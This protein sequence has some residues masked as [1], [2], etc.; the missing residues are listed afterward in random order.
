MLDQ[1]GNLLKI[2]KFFITGVQQELIKN[3]VIINKSAIDIDA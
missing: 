2:I 1:K 3:M